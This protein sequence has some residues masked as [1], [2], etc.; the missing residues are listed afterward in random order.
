MFFVLPLQ[1]VCRTYLVHT[2]PCSCT[3]ARAMDSYVGGRLGMVGGVSRARGSC[4]KR[5]LMDCE[6]I[7]LLRLSHRDD[8]AAAFAARARG[9][10]GAP[11]LPRPPRPPLLHDGSPPSSGAPAEE[12]AGGVSVGE[13]QRVTCC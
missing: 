1:R 8:M 11:P 9:R 6:S 5:A 3:L 2:I 12:H 7:I 4:W 10:E 13:R